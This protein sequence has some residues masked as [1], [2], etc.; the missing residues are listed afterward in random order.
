MITPAQIDET[1]LV[2]LGTEAYPIRRLHQ[3]LGM[4][5]TRAT[6]LRSL[7]RLQDVGLVVREEAQKEKKL[8]RPRVFWRRA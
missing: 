3:K 1:V 5:H 4:A 2:A 6:V 7:K 8:G